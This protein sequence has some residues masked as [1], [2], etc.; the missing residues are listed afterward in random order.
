MIVSKMFGV[1]LP[2]KFVYAIF[3]IQCTND[4]SELQDALILQFT[5]LITGYSQHIDKILQDGLPSSPTGITHIWLTYW[6]SVEEFHSW[7]KHPDVVGFWQSLPDDAGMWREILTVPGDRAQLGTNVPEKTGFG[8]LGPAMSILDKT[9]YWGCYYDRKAAVT[10]ENHFPS[11]LPEAPRGRPLAKISSIRR[12]RV[13]MTQFPENICFVVEGQDHADITAAE[14][15][16]WFVNFDGP[17]SQWVNCLVTAGPDAGI[18]DA[19][20]CYVPES[21]EFGAST[22]RALNFNRKIQ[23]FYF[24]DMPAME[25][26]GRYNKGHV[27]LRRKFLESY[28]PGGV[29]A[30][31][32]ICLWVESSILRA[33]EMECEY[34]GCVEGTGMMRFDGHAAF[35]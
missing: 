19:R 28:G 4:P 25:R 27:G 12:G 33:E 34:V 13:H 31:G 5:N 21:G 20:L 24:Q 2:A 17:V 16:H 15:E 11:P 3:G 7:W 22:P 23:L 10:P 6:A 18:L 8:H 9:A 29:M 14:K 32:K 1:K 26:I 35:Q 30:E